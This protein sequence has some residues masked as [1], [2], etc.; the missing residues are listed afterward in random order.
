MC[1]VCVAY[2]RLSFRIY[3]VSATYVWRISRTN[4][5]CATY[6]LRTF[7]CCGICVIHLIRHTYHSSETYVAHT[8]LVYSSLIR[9]KPLSD[10]EVFPRRLHGVL[11][12]P[13]TPGEFQEK[14]YILFVK[15]GSDGFLTASSSRPKRCYGVRTAFYRVPAEFMHCKKFSWRLHDVFTALAQRSWCMHCVSTAFAPRFHGVLAL[16]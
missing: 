15:K 16:H 2:P 4:G 1:D 12:F 11:K 6:V 13:R 14:K 5:V 9:F 3:G 8:P 7:R 10:Q